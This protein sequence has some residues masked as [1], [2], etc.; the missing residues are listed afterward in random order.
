MDWE[1][2]L[3]GN[4]PTRFWEVFTGTLQN[5]LGAE[6]A[7]PFS[8]QANGVLPFVVMVVGL[9]FVQQVIKMIRKISQ[10]DIEVNRKD[11]GG[12]SGFR[13]E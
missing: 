13:N 5:F 2:T 11:S 7:G 6:S 4:F 9:M 8:D 3:G 1:V 10:G 12:L